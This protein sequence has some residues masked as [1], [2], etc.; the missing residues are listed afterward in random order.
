MIRVA[1]TGGVACG[2]GVVCEG[3][4]REWDRGCAAHFDCDAAVG[5]LLTDPGIV[6]RVTE[7]AGEE[8]SD[9]EG[10]LNRP[11]FRQRMFSDGDLR[12]RVEALL[13]PMV[14]ERARG[15][16]AQCAGEGVTLAL[17][18]VPLLFEAEFPLERDW[19]VAVGASRETQLRRM[20]E[21]RMIEEETGRRIIATQLPVAD[22][23]SRADF[24]LWNDGSAVALGDQ[25]AAL[26][27]RIRSSHDN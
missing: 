19:V 26:A 1:I 7:L 16:L 11:W 15:F 24:A 5:E 8:A 21:F 13:H 14:L 10:R 4:R 27:S 3:L 23:I 25:I 6:G 12:T 2:K 18:E 22:K 9:S 17:L 20:K